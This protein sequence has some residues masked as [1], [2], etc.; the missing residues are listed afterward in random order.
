MAFFRIKKIKNKEYAYVVE[1]E[2]HSKGS[3]QK[4][5][6]YLGRVYRFESKNNA[7]FLEFVKAGDAR[8]Y[9]ESNSKVFHELIEW[10][11]FKNGIDKKEFLIDMNNKK[12]QKNGR[13]VALMV[14]EGFLCS[15]TLKNLLEFKPEADG[16]NEGYRFAR[17]FI[18]AGI[19][20][21]HDVFIGLFG[22]MY[23]QAEIPKSDF[24]W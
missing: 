3:R 23:K 18:E 21:P 24:A 12:V 7:G 5:K 2:W 9:I 19:K 1:N 14:N 20:V 22:K 10:E 4:V 17:V 15:A 6:G 11:L 13:N 16:P 8:N